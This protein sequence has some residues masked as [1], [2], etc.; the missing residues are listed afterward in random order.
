ML[1]RISGRVEVLDNNGTPVA[2]D[3]ILGQVN[4]AAA[5]DECSNYFSN[6]FADL[7]ITGGT[8]KLTY[9]PVAKTMRVVTEYES[10]EKLTAADI[11]QLAEETRAMERWHWRRG[12]RRIGEKSQRQH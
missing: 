5:D 9:E 8:V 1:I 11:T 10:P 12:L 7:G 4:G 3:A 6:R 2:D